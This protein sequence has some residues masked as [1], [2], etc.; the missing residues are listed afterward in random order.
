M[1]IDEFQKYRRIV[2]S[3]KSTHFFKD[4]NLS[5][6]HKWLDESGRLD[7]GILSGI[8]SWLKRN[9]SVTARR[10]HSLADDY[11]KELGEELRAEWKKTK[12][13][14]DLASKFRAGTYNRA[15]RDI[16]ER[17]EI[18][19]ED[20]QDYRELVRT[21]IN[22]KDLKVKREILNELSGMID[23]EEF[24]DNLGD[25]DNDIRKKYRKAED[26]YEKASRSLLNSNKDT[27]KEI[28][29]YLIEKLRNEKTEFETI[30]IKTDVDRL[31]FIKLM[32]VY[33]N[34]LSEK[35]TD[36]EFT[37]KSI[38]AIAKEYRN[39][40]KEAAVKLKNK[41]YDESAAIKMVKKHIDQH[42]KSIKNVLP[43]SRLKSVVFSELDKIK[44][45]DSNE[46]GDIEDQVTGR[47][48]DDLMSD[49]EVE[50][51]VETAADETDKKDPSDNEIVKQ[52]KEE[53]A[54][55]FADDN[56]EEIVRSINTKINKFNS[57][58]PDE[59]KK[60]AKEKGFSLPDKADKV[61][62]VEIKKLIP[63]FIDIVGIVY[64]FHLKYE[65]SVKVAT[66]TVR[67]GLYVIH[68]ISSGKRG[69]LG[70]KDKDNVV[71][72]LKKLYPT[73]LE[74]FFGSSETLFLPGPDEN[75]N[76]NEGDA[77][78]DYK[79]G[80]SVY[81]L[82]KHGPDRASFTI[83]D[84]PR[85]TRMAIEYHA[86]YIKPVCD[87]SNAYER[88]AK[89]IVTE[90]QGEARLENGM[91]RMTSKARIRYES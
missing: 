51:A 39:F 54:E 12:D 44:K 88:T 50:N 41:G 55:L 83:L 66:K 19:A 26:E 58:D 61:N 62:I 21:L 49:E 23:P 77:S 45:D 89:R 27:I 75:G 16:A 3:E 86:Q 13:P 67:A 59:L 4:E 84:D 5:R 17:M 8:W 37:P 53:V 11:E 22:K 65:D 71:K 18:L 87:A 48:T 82:T 32:Y 20:D 60:F 68:M 35:I 29:K 31:E 70:G 63:I 85:A 64:P 33:V 28:E 47:N 69:S 7:E 57:D 6:V 25:I 9:F 72:V 56:L 76:F 15:S 79:E 34:A 46:D 78:K 91:W 52:I 81:K 1:K 80:A 43:L 73:E 30:D 24:K 40:V 42:L 14:K 10:I 36:V 38:Y 74:D 2:E 90:R